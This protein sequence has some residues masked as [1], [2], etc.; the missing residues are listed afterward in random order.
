MF[1]SMSASFEQL[2]FVTIAWQALQ[3]NKLRSFLTTLGIIIGVFAVIATVAVGEGAQA[4]IHA[5]FASMGSNILVVRSGGS[6]SGGVFGEVGSMA[7][8]TWDDLRAIR[9]EV[10]AVR[11][12]SPILHTGAQVQSEER[13]WG[14]SVNGVAPDYFDIREWP[15]VAGRLFTPS[16]V[17]SGTKVAVLGQTVA[18]KLFGVHGK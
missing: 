7:S 6:K 2:A 3:R 12:A 14:T 8:L 11:F 5:A 10:P 18:A 16:D 15:V 9:T 1:D 17:D 13:N 4:A